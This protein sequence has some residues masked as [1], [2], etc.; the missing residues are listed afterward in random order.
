LNT[1]KRTTSRHS[2]TFTDRVEKQNKADVFGRFWL[3]VPGSIRRPTFSTDSGTS[4][5]DRCALTNA[6]EDGRFRVPRDVISHLEVPEGPLEVQQGGIMMIVEKS[7]IT[8]MFCTKKS[9]ISSQKSLWT[10]S[11]GKGKKMHKNY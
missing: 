9:G 6:G 8:V 3:D 4:H 11:T 7:N 5:S 2:I 1:F 10:Q